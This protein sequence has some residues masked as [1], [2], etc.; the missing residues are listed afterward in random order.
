MTT[1]ITG[2]LLADYDNAVKKFFANGGVIA[3]AI[4]VA[5]THLARLELQAKSGSPKVT[6]AVIPIARRRPRK[7]PAKVGPVVGAAAKRA[8]VAAAK[9]TLFDTFRLSDGL[10]VG[11]IRYREIPAAMR[12]N[13]LDYHV[14]SGIQ[15][16]GQPIDDSMRVREY[17]KEDVLKQILD[18]YVV[19]NAVA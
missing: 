1:S 5:R 3:D 13:S 2:Q 7:K 8:A 16:H 6:A 4:T 19:P 17:L 9:A 12:K 11:D 14:L 15:A 18:Q 10:A